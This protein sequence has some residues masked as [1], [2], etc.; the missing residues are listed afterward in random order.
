MTI[1]PNVARQL[2]ARGIDP[3]NAQ[4]VDLNDDQTRPGLGMIQ[5]AF[6]QITRM[7]SGIVTMQCT[8]LTG[9]LEIYSPDMVPSER[10]ISGMRIMADFERKLKKEVELAIS[11]MPN[12]G[13]LTSPEESVKCLAELATL[14]HR[15]GKHAL[16]AMANTRDTM[17][18]AEIEWSSKKV[19]QTEPNTFPTVGT[20]GTNNGTVPKPGS[21][22]SDD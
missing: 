6:D 4:L 17:E 2:R 10:A 16:D 21:A 1:P 9:S 8:C 15:I 12:G 13:H 7:W 19:T 22:G 5:A 18:G 11:N 14:N 3:A 20:V